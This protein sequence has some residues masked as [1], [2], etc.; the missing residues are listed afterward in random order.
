MKKLAYHNLSTVPFRRRKS[1]SKPLKSFV[2]V[3]FLAV[4]TRMSH[5]KVSCNIKR[6]NHINMVGRRFEIV[7]MKWLCKFI[8]S[9]NEVFPYAAN[10]YDFLSEHVPQRGIIQN[11]S[12]K[13]IIEFSKWKTSACNRRLLI[14]CAWKSFVMHEKIL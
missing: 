5:N 10:M 2:V 11:E 12:V 4:K 3:L 14:S 9:N 1:G 7:Q 6:E 13:V 8:V